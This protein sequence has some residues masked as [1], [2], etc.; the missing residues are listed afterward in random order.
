[1]TDSLNN[2]GSANWIA[3]IYG[4]E[5][6]VLKFTKFELPGVSAGVTALGNRTEFIAQTG[7]GHIEYDNLEI[8][9]LVDEDL[10]NYRK[11]Y[12]WMRDNAKRGIDENVSIFVHF[13]GNDKQFQGVE[14][15]FYECFPIA[16]DKLE[17]DT[18]GHEADV[19]CGVTFAYTA[20]DFVD[21]TDRD[22]D[23]EL[24]YPRE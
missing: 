17:L 6:L 24:P 9:F 19:H 23:L 1:M 20:F 3:T 13:I 7:G 2:L 8:E 5:D 18:D 21:E 22:A 4:A 11:L 12:K 10:K 14:V 15:E 16:L